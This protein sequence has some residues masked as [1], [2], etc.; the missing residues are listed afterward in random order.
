MTF[1]VPLA[2][3]IVECRGGM[4]IHGAYHCPGIWYSLCYRHSSGN[5]TYQHGDKVTVDGYLGI[6]TLDKKT[7]GI[8]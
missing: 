3:S 1:I 6:V 4:L 8:F 5:F 2:A 7:L